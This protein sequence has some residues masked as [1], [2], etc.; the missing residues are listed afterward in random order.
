MSRFCKNA[1]VAF[2]AQRGGGL[3]EFG[4]SQR[5]LMSE[6]EGSTRGQTAGRSR[7][8]VGIGA[9]LGAIVFARRPT[10]GLS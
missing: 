10:D 2:Q 8:V 1:L 4:D 3:E 6:T 9:D 7:M 5:H